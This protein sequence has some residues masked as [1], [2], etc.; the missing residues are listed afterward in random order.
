MTPRR[1]VEGFVAQ[2]SG[3][4]G[5]IRSSALFALREGANPAPDFVR[6]SRI[7]TFNQIERGLALNSTKALH[8]VLQPCAFAGIMYWKDTGMQLL[9]KR[10]PVDCSIA[11]YCLELKV[12]RWSDAQ[13]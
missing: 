12:G 7:A 8:Q 9:D 11:L 3:L 6:L 4:H 10:Y 1:S 5:I 13:K 2:S